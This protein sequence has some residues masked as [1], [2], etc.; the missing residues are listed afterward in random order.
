MTWK[1][2]E[3]RIV[4]VRGGGGRTKVSA[5]RTQPRKLKALSNTERKKR[6]LNKFSG[7]R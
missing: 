7:G 2:Q 5:K 6:G 4:D 3:V 1:S